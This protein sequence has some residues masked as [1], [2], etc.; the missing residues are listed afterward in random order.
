MKK[1]SLYGIALLTL[2][3]P[4][5][6]AHA[7]DCSGLNKGTGQG[8]ACGMFSEATDITNIALGPSAAATQ[9]G[10]VAIGINSESSGIGSVALGSFSNSNGIFTI[11]L[12]SGAQ[13]HNKDK[14]TDTFTVD[15][16]NNSVA[17]KTDDGYVITFKER[18]VDAMIADPNRGPQYSSI[19]LGAT[20]RTYGASAIA[21]GGFATAYGHL[22]TAV[23]NVA[24]TGSD[25]A[26]AFGD[27][28]QAT[29][30]SSLALGRYAVAKTAYSV[31]SGYKA[32]AEGERAI[33]MGVNSQ[34]SG[35]YST[36]I[37]VDSK[38]SGVRA[39]ALGTTAKAEKEKSMA[40]GDQSTANANKATAV[41]AGASATH[42]NSVALGSDSTTKQ[43]NSVSVGSNANG[44][45]TTRTITNVTAGENDT[46]AV[47]VSQLKE[48]VSNNGAAAVAPQLT[49]ISNQVAGLS[50]AVDKNRK[51]ASSG[52]AAVAAMANIPVPSVI[53]KNTVGVG[54]GYHDGQSAL[55]IGAARYFENRI[56]VKASIATGMTNHKKATIGVGASYTW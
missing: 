50:N 8:L 16:K 12:G 3:T 10:A 56:A 18:E 35:R 34:S 49:N 46:D 9:G 14:T 5:P 11:A 40:L 31:A 42:E 33:A 25:G 43:D 13:T 47:N 1:V 45:E 52:I 37:G 7:E 30:K 17:T 39:V 54:L 6:L 55:A 36:A 29:G 41:G 23:G 44:Q 28:S 2:I 48:Y 15:A 21:M 53:G 38:A 51:Q 27:H 4:P 22:S 20:S 24:Q 32:K 19:A 26:S